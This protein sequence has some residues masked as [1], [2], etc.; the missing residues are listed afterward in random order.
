MSGD[1]GP[2][3]QGIFVTFEG[4]DG[5]GKS[6]HLRMLHEYL[7]ARGIPAVATKEPGG[8][9]LGDALRAIFLDPRWGEIDPVTELLMLTATRQQ[10]LHEIIEPGLSSGRN[11]LCDRFRDSTIVYQ[12]YGRKNGDPG[13]LAQEED[14]HTRYIKRMPDLTY[15]C[16]LDPAIAY[17]RSRT[18]ARNHSL[19]RLDREQVEFF[20]R[21]HEGFLRLAAQ[22]P[23]RIRVVDTSRPIEEAQAQIRE[24]FDRYLA[25]KQPV[26]QRYP[27]GTA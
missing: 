19:D 4:I 18:R 5:C 14:I 8:T 21:V 24:D 16:T 2:G 15:L 6:T 27:S 9:P 1:S 23:E 17:E 7:L 10:H 11:V 20:R 25:R 26:S 3:S 22:H 13:F 12:G